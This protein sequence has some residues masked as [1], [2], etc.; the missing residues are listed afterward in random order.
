MK[1]SDEI[2]RLA[3]EAIIGAPEETSIGGYVWLALEAAAPVIRREAL[4]EAAKH[5]DQQ[6]ALAMNSLHCGSDNDEF[7]AAH[8]AC[9]GYRASAKSILALAEKDT[10]S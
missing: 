4:M 5:L 2:R 1:I 3:G 7:R 6:A 8:K 9:D 10:T